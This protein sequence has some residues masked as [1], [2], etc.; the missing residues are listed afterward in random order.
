[1]KSNPRRVNFIL[2][3]GAKLQQYDA[4]RDEA[5]RKFDAAIAG[6]ELKDAPVNRQNPLPTNGQKRTMTARD[7]MR[8]YGSKN[9]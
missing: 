6:A 4:E 5:Q 9:G 7:I 1:M 2:S 8:N 3:C